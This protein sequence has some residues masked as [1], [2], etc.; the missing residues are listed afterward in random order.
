[1]SIS[2]AQALSWRMKRQL[3]EPV[4]DEAVEA[5]VQRL[6]AVP[7]MDEGLA[8]LAVRVRRTTSQPGELAQ[9]LVDGRVIKTFA[10]RGAMHYMSP[11]D[12]G[13]YLSIRCAGRQWE[14]PSWVEFY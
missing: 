9:A 4:G 10:F 7:S 6:G 13:A 8:E 1:M 14:L 3:L 12:G 11:E 2:W 5:V